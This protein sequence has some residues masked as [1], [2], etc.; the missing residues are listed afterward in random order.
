MTRT[1]DFKIMSSGKCVIVRLIGF[2]SMG[3][4]SQEIGRELERLRDQANIR[5]CIDCNTLEG[6]DSSGIGVLLL[7]RKLINNMGGVM[8]LAIPPNTFVRKALNLASLGSMLNIHDSAID[9]AN[10]LKSCHVDESE[11]FTNVLNQV[12]GNTSYNEQRFA[13]EISRQSK[14]I[15][16]SLSFIERLAVSA[17]K[18]N[19][20][21][22]WGQVITTRLDRL[23]HHVEAEYAH[24]TDL[25]ENSA[26]IYAVDRYA[27]ANTLVDCYLRNNKWITYNCCAAMNQFLEFA[28]EAQK[29]GVQCW[30]FCPGDNPDMNAV[31]AMCGELQCTSPSS[32][33]II[34]APWFQFAN[35]EPGGFERIS[36]CQSFNQFEEVM[37]RKFGAKAEA[38]TG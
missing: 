18:D 38:E 13:R 6:I 37:R 22:L 15:K 4:K 27:I 32:R 7:F 28:Q 11:L 5:V 17:L 16:G 34:Y 2:L 29:R 14:E 21:T 30:V 10:F 26:A 24:Y 20:N 33:F 36:V 19:L 3:T 35:K 25:P 8:S 1:L 31:A 12:C 9:S 23:C